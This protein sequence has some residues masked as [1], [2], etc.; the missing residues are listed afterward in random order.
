[1]IKGIVW[2]VML[3][4]MQ[5]VLGQTSLDMM[6]LRNRN[7]RTVRSFFQGIPIAFGDKAGLMV[8]G[9]IHRVMNDSL[10]IRQY[11]IRR[12]ATMWGTQVQDTV[13]TYFLKFHPNEIA[14]IRKPRRS[15]ELVRNGTIFMVGGTA[16]GLLH[17]VN[18]AYLK[19]PVLWS[20]V[21]TAGALAATGFI[22]NKLRTGRYQ[23]GRK[24]KLVYIDTRP[25]TGNRSGN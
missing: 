6:V 15:F 9:T 10:Y 4:L 20:T 24:Y 19:E 2:I 5:D 7:G 25:E 23:I 13:S 17:V 1:M 18:A 3:F 11:D 16:Y 8:E 22:M 12:T 14:W 21:A